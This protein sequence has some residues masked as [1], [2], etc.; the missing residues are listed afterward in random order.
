M[1]NSEGFIDF[2]AR[3]NTVCISFTYFRQVGFKRDLFRYLLFLIAMTTELSQ[4][5]NTMIEVHKSF[6]NVFLYVFRGGN[7]I[8]LQQCYPDYPMGFELV[9]YA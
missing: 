6:L 7:I 1:T 3:R 9:I 8:Y 4:K 5:N 2:L